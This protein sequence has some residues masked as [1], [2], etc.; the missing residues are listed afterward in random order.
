MSERDKSRF[1]AALMAAAAVFER[2]VT[3]QVTE[4]YFRVLERFSIEEVERGISTACATLKFFPKPVEL[5]DCIIGGQVALEDRAHLEA[6]RVLTAIKE[7]GTYESVHFDDPVTQAV[8]AQHFG[9]W[10]RF[11]E[12]RE[13]GEK[14]FI[15]DFAKAY[16]SFARAG[17]KQNSALPGRAEIENNFRGYEHRGRPAIIGNPETVG[18]MLEVAKSEPKRLPAITRVEPGLRSIGE[19][20]GRKSEGGF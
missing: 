11:A 3:P 17:I 7:V 14:W 19:I 16:A 12:M 15:K 5:V 20:L 10:H 4:I 18:R 9:G 2:T 8:I 1:A 6:T 13:D